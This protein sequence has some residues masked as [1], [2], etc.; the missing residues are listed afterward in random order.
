[1][2]KRNDRVSSQQETLSASL[3]IGDIEMKCDAG[4]GNNKSCVLGILITASMFTLFF[5]L[6]LKNEIKHIQ[7]YTVSLCYLV[8]RAV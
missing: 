2:P 4:V 6:Y 7:L 1:M 5:F 8:I 3:N